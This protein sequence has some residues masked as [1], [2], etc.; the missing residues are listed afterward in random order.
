[1][2]NL[3]VEYQDSE[4]GRGAE[5]DPAN[6]FMAQFAKAENWERNVAAFNA[7]TSEQKQL[8]LAAFGESKMFDDF[9]SYEIWAMDNSSPERHAEIYNNLKPVMAKK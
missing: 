6:V 8:V 3:I 4:E 9:S 2:G 1:M 7:A 5:D